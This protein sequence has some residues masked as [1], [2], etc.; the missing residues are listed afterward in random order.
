MHP[1]GAAGV[2]GMVSSAAGG[3]PGQGVRA[4]SWVSSPRT[5]PAP[6]AA[7]GSGPD[8]SFTPLPKLG[9]REVWFC[10]LAPRAWAAAG[11]RNP[12]PAELTLGL[13]LISNV[14]L[15]DSRD[16]AQKF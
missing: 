4:S 3:A 14:N 9:A 10:L 15:T 16:F 5:A 13:S 8:A 7:A 11:L 1:H 2:G 12:S 6:K